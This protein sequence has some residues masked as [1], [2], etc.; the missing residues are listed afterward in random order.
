MITTHLFSQ[1]RC[2]FVQLDSL[3]VQRRRKP[4]FSSLK[5]QIQPM[6]PLDMHPLYAQRHRH[7]SNPSRLQVYCLPF[8]FCVV[9]FALL[10]PGS[11]PA[12]TTYKEIVEA[13]LITQTCC[14][15]SCAGCFKSAFL[16][17]CSLLVNGR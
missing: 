8:S 17:I 13:A 4:C 14:V 16:W 6:N 12:H 3:D 9:A 11:S 1:A 7:K 15:Q 5:C 10:W 2:C